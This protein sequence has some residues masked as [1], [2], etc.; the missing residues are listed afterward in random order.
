MLLRATPVILEQFFYVIV[1]W[2]QNVPLNVW[3]ELGLFIYAL[4]SAVVAIIPTAK[5]N[6]IFSLPV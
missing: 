4:Q 6:K 3:A 5:P 2:F 1:P